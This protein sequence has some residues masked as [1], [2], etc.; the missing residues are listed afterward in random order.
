MGLVREFDIPIFIF[1]L[2][3]TY[4][5]LGVPTYLTMESLSCVWNILQDWSSTDHL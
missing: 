4:G 3:E 5:G 2:Q 1:N